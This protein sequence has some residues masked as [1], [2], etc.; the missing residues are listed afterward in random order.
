MNYRNLIIL[1]ASLIVTV[2]LNAQTLTSPRIGLGLIYGGSSQGGMSEFA[3]AQDLS[4]VFTLNFRYGTNYKTR[5]K[6]GG[7]VEVTS[8]IIGR[9]SPS[10]GLEYY[11]NIQD[12]SLFGVSE[13]QKFG[14]WDVPIMLNYKVSDRFNIGLGGVMS[15]HNSIRLNT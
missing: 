8:F 3:L 11:Y 7:G 10:I 13:I 4:D 2:T 9:F 15:S 14:N 12:N 6:F 5:S 1:V